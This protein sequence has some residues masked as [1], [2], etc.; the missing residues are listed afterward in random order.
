MSAN[1][2]GILVV[3]DDFR[4]ADIHRAFIE[5]SEGFEVVAVARNGAEAREQMAR[6]ASAIQLVLLHAAG[7]GGFDQVVKHAAAQRLADGVYLPRGGHHDDIHL[8][9]IATQRPE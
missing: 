6:H 8:D 1:E 9:V 7:L 5:Q 2:Y 3:E 4:I